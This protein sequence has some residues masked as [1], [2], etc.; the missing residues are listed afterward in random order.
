MYCVK[1]LLEPRGGEL[2]RWG[3][4]TAI[5]AMVMAGP[6][7]GRSLRGAKVRAKALGGRVVWPGEG[8]ERQ[9]TF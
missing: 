5:S 2:G 8:T 7:E 3:S 4:C 6:R 1:W 9:V